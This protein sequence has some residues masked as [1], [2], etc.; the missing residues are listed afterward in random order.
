M[1]KEDKK[2][3]K[4]GLKSY[5]EIY[6]WS[7]DYR[8]KTL[9]FSG[10]LKRYIDDHNIKYKIEPTQLSDVYRFKFKN[11]Y[12]I[13]YSTK[14]LISDFSYYAK[15]FI[16]MEAV[17]MGDPTEIRVECSWRPTVTVNR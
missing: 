1:T 4:E 2:K 15:Q 14:G 7:I 10:S 16:Q 12:G 17:R 11:D 9:C 13:Q 3:L 6:W 8:D 5:C